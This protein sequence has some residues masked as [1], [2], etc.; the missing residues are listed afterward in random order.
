MRLQADANRKAKTESEAASANQHE[1]AIILMSTRTRTSPGTGDLISHPGFDLNAF[2]VLGDAL[3]LKKKKNMMM[4]DSIIKN[5]NVLF[6][7]E[8]I[9]K[10]QAEDEGPEGQD[11][12]RCSAAASSDQAAPYTGQPW[13]ELGHKWCPARSATSTS[14]LE[15]NTQT[16]TAGS[17]NR[18][19][20]QGDGE[21]KFPERKSAFAEHVS[22][23]GT[24]VRSP[25]KI[26][27]AST[28]DLE[29]AKMGPMTSPLQK[30]WEIVIGDPAKSITLTPTPI[31]LSTSVN[32][33]D[34]KPHGQLPKRSI[35]R[36]GIKLSELRRV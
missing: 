13:T 19:V 14:S 26:D 20:S 5:M 25:A 8:V 32:V 31:P 18:P 3:K 27:A 10:P 22:R 12:E 23:G 17:I 2:P 30:L 34:V 33:Y 21:D 35:S 36:S 1:P 6:G 7:A 11:D 29:T 15:G 24:P 9:L 16:G 28:L 4:R